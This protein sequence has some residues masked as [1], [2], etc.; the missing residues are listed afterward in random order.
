MLAGVVK[1]PSRLAPTQQSRRRAERSRLVLTAMVDS[2]FISAARAQSTMPGAPGRR[3][4]TSCRPAP[5]S[6]T[7]SRLGAQGVR[8]RLR[9]GEGPHH[10]RA[11]PAA[12]GGPRRPPR[13]AR[14]RPGGAGRDA[15][16]RPGRRDGR[17]PE[18]RAAPFNRA[19]Q[20][21]RQPGSAFKLFVYLAALR[22]GLTPDSLIDDAPITI[23]DWS[24]ATATAFIAA[25]SRC[26]TP[27]RVRA[28][29]RG[30]AVG[31]GSAAPMSSRRRA[32]SAS[33]RRL[34]DE[35]EP[36]ARHRQRQP[37]RADLGLCRGRRGR[38]PIRARPARG[39]AGRKAWRPSSG[40]RRARSAAR[41]GDDAR[42]ALRRGQ[43]RHRP[44]R[45]A[46]GAD[47]RQDR[48]HPGLSRRLVR[49]LRR[50]SGGRRLGR[51]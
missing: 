18:L 39:A 28:T 32:I 41:L 38:Y 44:P 22:A 15:A 43:Q 34:P 29:R 8:R 7:G 23:G 1:A 20:A 36:A 46:G 10:A 9:R 14:R 24:P 49:R 21:R 11:R 2:G 3:R 45:G 35:P 42:P 37:A 40:R 26:A 25:R 47:L 4:T 5:I 48:H 27:S 13:A 12:A 50:R 51:Q 33:P 17:R 16:R 6:P 19:T 30:A 31:S